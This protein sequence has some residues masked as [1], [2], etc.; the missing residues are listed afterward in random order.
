MC[1]SCRM[2]NNCRVTS[3][4]RSAITWIVHSSLVRTGCCLL[5]VLMLSLPSSFCYLIMETWEPIRKT[6]VGVD[7][8]NKGRSSGRG[9]CSVDRFVIV[10]VCILS[11]S[12]ILCLN[13][14]IWPGGLSRYALFCL[15]DVWR[16]ISS[17]VRWLSWF[18]GPRELSPNSQILVWNDQSPGCIS[19]ALGGGK[20]WLRFA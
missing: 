17:L 16:R 13:P 12:C 9:Q 2:C 19:W 8:S 10:G 5:T 14:P 6:S 20:Q 1:N 11:L 18:F 15:T 3:V 7:A 4:I